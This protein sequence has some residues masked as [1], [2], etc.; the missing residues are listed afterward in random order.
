MKSHI[1]TYC[2]TYAKAFREAYGAKLGVEARVEELIKKA[3][4]VA[5]KDI[6]AVNI[7]GTAFKMTSK[8]LGIKHTKKAIA[9]YLSQNGT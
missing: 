4:A 9:E 7:D 1:D 2:E 6:Y 5:C 3:L 8:R